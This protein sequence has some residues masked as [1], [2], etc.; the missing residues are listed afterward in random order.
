MP[1]EAP[2]LSIVVPALREARN[3]PLLAAQMASVLDTWVHRWELIIVDDR[4]ES[5]LSSIA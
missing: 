3:I 1:F 5:S 4:S 2:H